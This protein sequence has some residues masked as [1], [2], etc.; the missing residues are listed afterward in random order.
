[1]KYLGDGRSQSGLTVVNVTDS[2]DVD[3]RLGALE[4]RLSHFCPPQDLSVTRAVIPLGFWV[5]FL[6]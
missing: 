2:T 3:V 5:C 6:S 4:F 1:M